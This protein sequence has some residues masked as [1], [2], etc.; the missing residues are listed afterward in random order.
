MRTWSTGYIKCTYLSHN[1]EGSE[2]QK[3]PGQINVFMNQDSDWCPLPA[4]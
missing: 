4:S 3:T 1:P 2:P